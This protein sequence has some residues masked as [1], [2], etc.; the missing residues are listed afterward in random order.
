M[1]SKRIH[2]N[3]RRRRGVL[4]SVVASIIFH[5]VALEVYQHWFAG[6][7]ERILR[8]VRFEQRPGIAQAKPYRPPVPRI[9]AVVLEQLGVS[10]DRLAP[11]APLPDLEGMILE[12]PGVP[13][14]ARLPGAR[15]TRRPEPAPDLPE[16]EDILRDT[17]EKRAAEL[18]DYSRVW[19]PDADTTDADT[20][21]LRQAR[22][23]IAAAVEAM[24]GAKALSQVRDMRYQQRF[25]KAY[26]TRSQYAQRLPAGARVIFDGERGFIDL[27]GRRHS[28]E[29]RSLREIRRRAERWDF[30]SRYM[31]AGVDI[32]YARKEHRDLDSYD[33]LRVSDLR[34]G[35]RVFLAYF[36]TETGLPHHEDYPSTRD[37]L[38]LK[39]PA[40]G[41]F[42]RNFGPVGEALLWHQIAILNYG[43]IR[44]AW[45]Y[46]EVDYRPIDDDTFVTSPPPPEDT[47]TLTCCVSNATLWLDLEVTTAPTTSDS[48]LPG[49][50]SL[51]NG[52]LRDELASQLRAT[53]L[54]ILARQQYFTHVRELTEA[55]PANGDF[56]L[57][58]GIKGGPAEEEPFWP[59]PPYYTARLRELQTDQQVMQDGPT[60][61]WYSKTHPGGP[62][63]PGCSS[64]DLRAYTV[65]AHMSYLSPRL[66]E[67]R[68]ART[69][70]KTILSVNEWADGQRRNFQYMNSCCYC[71]G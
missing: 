24:G 45:S 33:V 23:V 58:I 53:A 67:E 1:D 64:Y 50:P 31:G 3:R 13:V 10:I 48:V 22:R 44:Y 54:R 47:H 15:Q 69:L 4:I 37:S 34:F 39:E 9:P 62:A 28:L 40:T 63:D 51:L 60:S 35:G 36:D 42:F 56:H 38:F 25:H 57:T 32:T 61:R 27:F 20:E 68:L 41:H 26:G 21:N 30:L 70:R 46:H 66:L 8:P 7:V 12:L 55:E 2:Q 59:G 29:G 52:Y 18:E 5:V 19:T 49:A 65:D 14:P 16:L 6:Q 43:A 71:S 11:L 17:I